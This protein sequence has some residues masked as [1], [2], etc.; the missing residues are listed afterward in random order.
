MPRK[1]GF[2]VVIEAIGNHLIYEA[3]MVAEA[4]SKFFF[5]GRVKQNA[6]SEKLTEPAYF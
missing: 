6:G 4:P 1:V 5:T 2:K 3:T